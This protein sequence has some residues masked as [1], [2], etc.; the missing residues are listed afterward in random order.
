M[1]PWP[2]FS[3]QHI[4]I[5][6]P[7]RASNI[8][9]GQFYPGR[10]RRNALRA[11]AFQSLRVFSG[12]GALIIRKRDQALVGQIA[13]RTPG[14]VRGVFGEEFLHAWNDADMFLLGVDV[15]RTRY[16]VG[17]RRNVVERRLDSIDLVA[18]Q[19]V[20]VL[21]EERESEDAE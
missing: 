10:N 4:G 16:L 1:P 3:L 12:L 8:R 20:R 7:R 6:A 21:I 2:V 15:E 17:A 13:I 11:H 19:L 14:G 5:N 9:P 18:L